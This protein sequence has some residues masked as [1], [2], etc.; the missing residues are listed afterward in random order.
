MRTD[1]AEAATL[2]IAGVQVDDRL[3][4]QAD[5]APGALHPP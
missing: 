3:P 4:V 2:G 1:L 5:P